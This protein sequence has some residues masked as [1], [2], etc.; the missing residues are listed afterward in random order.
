MTFTVK[1]DQI[2]DTILITYKSKFLVVLR[3]HCQ[4]KVV[5]ETSTLI[6]SKSGLTC[7]IHVLEGK[8]WGHLSVTLA[9]QKQSEEKLQS[10]TCV[11]QFADD[12]WVWKDSS[13]Q[14]QQLKS[15]HPQHEGDWICEPLWTASSDLQTPH[16]LPDRH[17]RI[18]KFSRQIIPMFFSNSWRR[19]LKK[20]LNE[21][22]TQF[23]K[24]MGGQLFCEA[25]SRNVGSSLSAV[26]CQ[27]GSLTGVKLLACVTEYKG[28]VTAVVVP[29]NRGINDIS[30]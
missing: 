9:T 17:A 21:L 28:I 7:W 6:L 5:P 11:A 8:S 26:Q 15:S 22:P 16:A 23:L 14:C 4:L 3:L 25:C 10:C 24:T 18:G 30:M 29:A 13:C 27:I 1:N 12:R 20:H 2:N 19:T